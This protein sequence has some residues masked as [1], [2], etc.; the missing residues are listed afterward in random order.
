MQSPLSKR[1]AKALSHQAS[2]HTNC[3]NSLLNTLNIAFRIEWLILLRRFRSCPD[4]RG[5]HFTVE[6]V[7]VK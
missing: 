1:E 4:Q 7:G 5:R 3:L 2:T 6:A